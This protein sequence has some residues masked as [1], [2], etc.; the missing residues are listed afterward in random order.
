LNGEINCLKKT[1]KMSCELT[2]LRFCNIW[3]P[4]VQH[5]FQ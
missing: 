4:S 2:D 3:L 5:K 1:V